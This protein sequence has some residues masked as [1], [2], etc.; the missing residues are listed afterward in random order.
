MNRPTNFRRL[1]FCLAPTVVVASSL[2]SLAADVASGQERV[3]RSTADVRERPAD[4]L[5]RPRNKERWSH[6]GYEVRTNQFIVIANTRVEDAR[7]V[8][9]QMETAWQPLLDGWARESFPLGET[10]LKGVVPYYW[11]VQEG[12]FA[13]DIAFRSD[14]PGRSG[15][16]GG[17]AGS[18]AGASVGT[19]E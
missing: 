14:V 18:K 10:F 19:L 4:E 8:S 17:S 3:Q 11:S 2:A 15:R 5:D 12:E 16:K 9:Q 1:S 7:W 13:T 6:R